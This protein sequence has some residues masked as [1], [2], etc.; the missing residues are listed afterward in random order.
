MFVVREYL[1][2]MLVTMGSKSSKGKFNIQDTMYLIREIAFE[3]RLKISN[4]LIL[5]FRRESR[6]GVIRR[7]TPTYLCCISIL[8]ISMFSLLNGTGYTFVSTYSQFTIGLVQFVCVHKY[9]KC[10]TCFVFSS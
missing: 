4:I 10:I 7:A 5:T 8:Y 3:V 2:F 6:D 1:L 9:N